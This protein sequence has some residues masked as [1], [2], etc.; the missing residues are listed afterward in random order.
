MKQMELFQTS[1]TFPIL[2]NFQ[3][4]FSKCLVLSE[5]CLIVVL[6]FPIGP[7]TM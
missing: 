5:E 7:E 3:F 4:H 6:G 1:A 2:L